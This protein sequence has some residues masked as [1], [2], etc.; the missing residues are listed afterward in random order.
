MKDAQESDVDKLGKW[1]RNWW[2]VWFDYV[3]NIELVKAVM[4]VRL[5]EVDDEQRVSILDQPG[6][7]LIVPQATLGGRMKGKAIQYHRNIDKDRG[8]DMYNMLVELCKKYAAT[9]PKWVQ[10]GCR[11]EFGTYGIRQVYSTQTNGPFLHI[12]EFWRV[13]FNKIFFFYSFK[14]HILCNKM[15]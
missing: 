3:E 7:I 12:I 14:I 4:S 9:N 2:I 1:N 11:V 5:S 13:Y 6:S 15:F 8:L 10:S